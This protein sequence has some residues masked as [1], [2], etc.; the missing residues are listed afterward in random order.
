[1]AIGGKGMEGGRRVPTITSRQASV[2][3]VGQLLDLG[4]NSILSR[5]GLDCRDFVGCGGR[6]G[7][8][9]FGGMKRMLFLVFHCPGSFSSKAYPGKRKA[10]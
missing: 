8:G 3:D 4:G 9:W 6:G 1:M 7:N 2:F 10:L 5:E